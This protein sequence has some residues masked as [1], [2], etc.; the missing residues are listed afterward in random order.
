MI[1]FLRLPTF[2][3]FILPFVR[4]INAESQENITSVRPVYFI[5]R[6]LLRQEGDIDSLNLDNLH[7]NST[8]SFY[9][10]NLIS[11]VFK[12]LGDNTP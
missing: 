4:H 8:V 2:D 12:F 6:A 9:E 5:P 3:E 7:K 1:P 10:G 11:L